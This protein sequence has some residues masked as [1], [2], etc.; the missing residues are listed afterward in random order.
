MP[1][2]FTLLR[3]YWKPLLIALILA[4]GYW[5]ISSLQ[6]DNVALKATIAAYKATASA[7]VERNKI[8]IKQQEQITAD[9]VQS[10]SNSVDK[11]KDYYAKN[12]TIKLKPVSVCSATSS[13]EVSSIS[14]ATVSTHADPES[15]SAS[16][17][18]VTALDCAQDV[19]TLLS[20]Q[21]WSKDQALIK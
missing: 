12:P 4:L 5:Y 6:S 13:R 21:K 11:L 20:L 14:A 19:L 8:I 9:V 1:V 15:D 16:A 3:T 2:M 7:Q 17:V 18:G 10:Y